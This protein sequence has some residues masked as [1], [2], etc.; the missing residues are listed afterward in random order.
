MTDQD[1]KTALA[2]PIDLLKESWR[3]Y[4]ERFWKLMGILLLPFGIGV[5]LIL[6]FS[7]VLFV[8]GIFSFD[9][10]GSLG[11]E[12]GVNSFISSLVTPSNAVLL[13][14]LGIIFLLVMVIAQLWG[15]ISLMTAAVS[16]TKL[17]VKEAYKKSRGKILRYFGLTLIS[18]FILWGAM[19]LFVVPGII[20]G[21]SFS[22][23]TFVLLSEN[24]G[25]VSALARSREYVKSHWWGVLGRTLFINLIPALVSSL[26]SRTIVTFFNN[27][28]QP[29]IGSGLSTISSL[30]GVVLGPLVVVYLARMYL[31]LREIKGKVV[32]SKKSKIAY[33]LIG[34]LGGVIL[35]LGILAAV[36]L[37][38]TNPMRA[39]PQP[40]MTGGSPGQV[41][42][43]PSPVID[44]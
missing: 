33:V 16:E 11:S 5:I 4:K 9:S 30:A 24:I 10:L 14:I 1:H 34:V 19:L 38:L 32:V 41:S 35:P 27:I 20:L 8:L 39:T 3:I 18:S 21:V 17:G 40:M 26:S 12:A 25:G 37:S 36:F 22:L 2:G 43:I 7:V 13:L 31:N 29:Y 23:A 44:D 28:K 42:A 6:L 15:Q